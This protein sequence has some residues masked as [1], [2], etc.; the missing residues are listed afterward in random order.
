MD[1]GARAHL[2][3][4]LHAHAGTRVRGRGPS[5]AFGQD[6]LK[7]GSRDSGFFEL[8]F[9]VFPDRDLQVR[10]RELGGTGA[11]TQHGRAGSS[12]AAFSAVRGRRAGVPDRAAPSQALRH[13]AP[14]GATVG[15][16]HRQGAHLREAPGEPA[17]RAWGCRLTQRSS[18]PIGVAASPPPGVRFRA[19]SRA[20]SRSPLIQQLW[21]RLVSPQGPVRAQK[22][23]S[24]PSPRRA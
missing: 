22:A 8:Y 4:H 9:R 18:S 15:Q 13:C 3:A 21:G 5:A 17:G 12:L 6:I 23:G 14:P 10:C 11:S 2:H 24:R 16:G 1:T 20:Q 19:G 7:A